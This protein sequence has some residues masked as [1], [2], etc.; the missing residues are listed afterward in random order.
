MAARL[1]RSGESP[2]SV[3]ATMTDIFEWNPRD[4]L[5][6]EGECFEKLSRV[7][8]AVVAR[9]P[10]TLCEVVQASPPDAWRAAGTVMALSITHPDVPGAVHVYW[11]A[12]NPGAVRVARAAGP[13]FDQAMRDAIAAGRLV[14][15]AMVRGKGFIPSAGIIPPPHE[16]CFEVVALRDRAHSPPPSL[17]TADPEAVAAWVAR[18]HFTATEIVHPKPAAPRREAPAVAV[19]VTWDDND[20]RLAAVTSVL[21]MKRLA[22]AAPRTR[23]GTLDRKGVMLLAPLSDGGDSRRADWIIARY[24]GPETLVITVDDVIAANRWHRLDLAPWLWRRDDTVPREWMVGTD[25][26]RDEQ[27]RLI[28]QGAIP[29]ALELAGVEL[30]TETRRLLSGRRLSW[31]SDRVADSWPV[32]AVDAFAR[33]AP[34]LL[35]GPAHEH[36]VERCRRGDGARLVLLPHQ[37][38]QSK[39][40]IS[41]VPG[42][43]PRLEVRSTASNR[44]LPLALWQR[45]PEN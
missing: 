17:L 38:Q 1:R 23:R 41:L 16:P 6:G 15:G 5:P 27:I 40:G 14:P 42:R 24:A 12:E 7:R 11:L 44:V 2:L 25:P 26:K 28:E 10:G 22:A 20:G 8:A 13:G 31:W 30:D 21:D 35:A 33:C 39:L 37:M 19:S 34:W 32:A 9:T 18:W 4:Y 45:P 3:S 43:K 36:V 29:T